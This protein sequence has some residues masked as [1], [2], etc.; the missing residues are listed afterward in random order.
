MRVA[1]ITSFGGPDV[2]RIVDRPQPAYEQNEVLVRMQA[3]SVNPVD[4]Y[5]RRGT[6]SSVLRSRFPLVL[7]RDGSGTVVAVGRAVTRFGIGD[8]VFF[9]N[10]MP[11]NGNAFGTY[12]EYAAV[13]E[14]QLAHKPANISYQE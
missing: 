4:T 9:M 10:D 6:F 14:D 11:L 3:A 5:T 13:R 1:Q 2:F 7:G 12:A 8:D